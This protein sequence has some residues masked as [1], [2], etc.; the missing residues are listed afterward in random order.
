MGCVYLRWVCCKSAVKSIEF[1]EFVELSIVWED[2]ECE[3]EIM[4]G[5]L[6]LGVMNELFIDWFGYCDTGGGELEDWTDWTD[7]TD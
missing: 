2:W 1:I 5:L 7:W 6:L 4:I 3:G